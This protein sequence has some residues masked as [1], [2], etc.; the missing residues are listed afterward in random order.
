MGCSGSFWL[1]VHFFLHL[2]VMILRQYGFGVLFYFQVPQVFCTRRTFRSRCQDRW[3]EPRQVHWP[4]RKTWNSAG[5]DA[6]AGGLRVT[7]GGGSPPNGRCFN[8]SFQRNPFLKKA[9]RKHPKSI[10][11]VTFSSR[12]PRF[13]FAP[14]M[15][16]T[17]LSYHEGNKQRAS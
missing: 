17:I 3:K 12:S 15:R 1:V 8:Q 2:G 13:L 7:L 9:F 16:L 10:P 4:R 14:G 6:Q 11:L 5:K